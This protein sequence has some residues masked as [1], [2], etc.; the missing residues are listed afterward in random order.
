[1]SIL[2]QYPAL[3]QALREEM[4]PKFLATRSAD[5][6]PNVVPCTSLMPAGDAEDRL[7]FGNF[8]LRKSVG[9]LDSDP[10]VGV[11]VVTP[12]LEGWVLQG[13]FLGWQR[14][15]PY[16]DALMNTNLLRYNAYT[17]VRNAGIIQLGAIRRAFRIPRPSGP[18]RVPAGP[19]LRAALSDGRGGTRIGADFGCG[20]RFPARPCVSGFGRLPPE[21]CRFRSGGAFGPR[22]AAGAG[23]SGRCG[24][25]PDRAGPLPA[26]GGAPVCWRAPVASP[27]TGWPVSLRARLSRPRC[28]RWTSSLSRPKGAGWGPPRP[29]PARGR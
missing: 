9:N 11:M 25:A 16:V 3:L 28:S 5:G 24:R 2:S 19:P 21:R 27:P 12:A 18:G 7:I 4:V 23:L 14:T 8:L 22:S 29:G 13:E 6:V 26:A 20:P 17:G 1:M 10:R 15:G